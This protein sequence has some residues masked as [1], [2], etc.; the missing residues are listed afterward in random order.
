MPRKGWCIKAP[1]VIRNIARRDTD[2]LVTVMHSGVPGENVSL[3]FQEDDGFKLTFTDTETLAE[4]QKML[5][6]ALGL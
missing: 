6:R 4:L 5:R 3:R 1:A 2:V